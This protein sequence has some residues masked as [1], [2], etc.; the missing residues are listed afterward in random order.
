MLEDAGDRVQ[1]Y[2]ND[3]Q[4]RYELGR[5]CSSSTAA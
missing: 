4:F 5:R 3:L 2:P 1:R